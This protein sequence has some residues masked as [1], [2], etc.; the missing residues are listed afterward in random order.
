MDLTGTSRSRVLLRD[1]VSEGVRS[2]SIAAVAMVPFGLLFLW[3]GLRI[4][5]YGPRVVLTFFEDLPAG[6]RFALFVLQHFLISWGAAVPLIAVLLGARGKIPPRV[7]GALY[8]AGFYLIVNA[9][10]LPWAF[11]DQPLWQLA[12]GTWLPSLVVHMVYGVAVAWTSRSFVASHASRS[13]E[14]VPMTRL[15]G[16]A[17]RCRC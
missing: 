17:G 2:G 16:F 11:G 4:N 6:V 7:A 12:A 10:A 1:L 5:E 13:R 9:L 15:G 8:G 14:A 3:S